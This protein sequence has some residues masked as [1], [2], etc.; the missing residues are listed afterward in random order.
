MLLVGTPIVYGFYINIFFAPVKKKYK[1]NH[2]TY[3]ASA[4]LAHPPS[5]NESAAAMPS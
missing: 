5:A 4:P 2:I 1:I 3:I